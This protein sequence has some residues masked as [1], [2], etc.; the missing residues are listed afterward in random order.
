MTKKNT[1][2]PTRPSDPYARAENHVR[3]Y[4]AQYLDNGFY[5]ISNR[6]AGELVRVLG[7]KLPRHGCEKFVMISTGPHRLNAWLTRTDLRACL[8][9]DIEHARGWRWALH[10][11]RADGPTVCNFSSKLVVLGAKF[12]FEPISSTSAVAA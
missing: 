4:S 3:A 12:V 10:G 1:V 6:A 5:V 2:N 8:R 9:T 7:Q 11:I